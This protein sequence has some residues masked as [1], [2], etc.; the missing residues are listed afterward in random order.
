MYPSTLGVSSTTMV[1]A[2]MRITF[3]SSWWRQYR[4]GERCSISLKSMPPWNSGMAMP[5]SISM[6]HI[7]A[8][9]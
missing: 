6:A 5:I 1:M 2:N 7:G 8:V 4:L 3:S 9:K